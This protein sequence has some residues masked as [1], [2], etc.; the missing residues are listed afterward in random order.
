MFFFSG[1]EVVY[2]G[3]R[4]ACVEPE[5]GQASL[6]VLPSDPSVMPWSLL[7][8]TGPPEI[9]QLPCALP[10]LQH[11]KAL[12]HLSCLGPLLAP[13]STRNRTTSMRPFRAA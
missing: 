3:W 6:H 9:E 11:A 4:A 7:V 2:I 5:I 13:D 10:Q 1:G 8:G 12:L